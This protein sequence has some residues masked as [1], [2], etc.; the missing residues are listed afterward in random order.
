MVE[1]VVLEVVVVAIVA[2]VLLRE[3][4][5]RRCV[6]IA[7]R[8]RSRKVYLLETSERAIQPTRATYDASV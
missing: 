1:I 5:N 3:L 6:T 8:E 2:Q 7:R 4:A